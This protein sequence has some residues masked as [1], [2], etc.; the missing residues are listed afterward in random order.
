MAT[1]SA[2]FW[3]VWSTV[4]VGWF[5]FVK[6]TLDLMAVLGVSRAAVYLVGLAC[7]V[8]WSGSRCTWCG[9][10]RRARAASR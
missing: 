3:F 1:P 2:R 4:L 5:L 10:I 6:V 7:G 9:A 8:V